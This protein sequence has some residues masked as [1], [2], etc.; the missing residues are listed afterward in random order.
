MASGKYPAIN[1]FPFRSGRG[2]RSG[3]FSWVACKVILAL[4]TIVY[5]LLIK[6]IKPALRFH[7][8]G[9]RYRDIEAFHLC[10]CL[11][12]GVVFLYAASV[13]KG[14]KVGRTVIQNRLNN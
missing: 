5:L 1:R 2:S 12:F 14:V 8:K 9:V 11:P 10:R 3:A 4:F 13:K 7:Y 6:T